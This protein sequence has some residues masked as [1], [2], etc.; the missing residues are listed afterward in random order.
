MSSSIQPRESS[1]VSTL[2]R[3][4]YRLSPAELNVTS[5]DPMRSVTTDEWRS[6][7]PYKT[8]YTE[9]YKLVTQC[10]LGN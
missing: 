9:I 6:M 1:N 10:E 2:P 8:L 7:P 3:V 4:T 5:C